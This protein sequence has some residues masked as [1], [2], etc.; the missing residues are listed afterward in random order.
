MKNPRSLR[1]GG[2]RRRGKLK[3]GCC[4]PITD[5]AKDDAVKIDSRAENP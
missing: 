2:L 3:E 5:K 4:P 1:L